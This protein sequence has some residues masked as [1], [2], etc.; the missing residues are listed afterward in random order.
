MPVTPPLPC[1][2]FPA[3]LQ[4]AT[5]KTSIVANRIPRDGGVVSISVFSET[6]VAQS[7]PEWSNEVDHSL[8]SLTSRCRGVAGEREPYGPESIPAARSVERRLRQRLE[9]LVSFFC[10]FYTPQARAGASPD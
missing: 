3:A 10:W 2:S 9:A 5:G 1:P 7:R 6:A 4:P 8:I